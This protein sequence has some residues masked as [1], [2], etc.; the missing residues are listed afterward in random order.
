M[1]GALLFLLKL[2]HAGSIP[3]ELPRKYKVPRRIHLIAAMLGFALFVRTSWADAVV[4]QNGQRFEGIIV[5]ETERRIVI[6]TPG[7]E[8]TIPRNK[9]VSVERSTVSSN[10]AIEIENALRSEAPVA[11]LRAAL[12]AVEEGVDPESLSYTFIENRTLI[13]RGLRESTKAQ[14]NE[15]RHLL[16]GLVDT[17]FASPSALH[18]MAQAYLELNS[19]LEASQCLHKAGLETLEENDETREWARDFLRRL[20]RELVVQGRHKEAVEQ[21]ERL[22]LVDPENARGQLPLLFLSTS[23][24]AREDD[25]FEEACRIL[26][27]ELAPIMPEIAANRASLTLREMTKWAERHGREKQAR[28]LLEI[29][30]MPL[31]PL[32]SIAARQRLYA[33]QARRHLKEA[34]PLRALRA[35]Q[36]VPE[37]ERSEELKDLAREAD[38]QARLQDIEETDA[39]SLFDLGIW[40]SEQG[41]Y[42]QA[43]DIFLSVR[44]NDVL[45][46]IVD[47]QMGLMKKE[48]DMM[49]LE[50]ALELYDQGLMEQAVEVCNE[51]ELNPGRET[52]LERQVQELAEL[53]RKELRQESRRRPY[54]AEAFY[55]QAERAY[56]TEDLDLAWRMIDLILSEYADTPAAQRAA[57]LLPDVARQ[58]ELQL[59]EGRRKRVPDYGEAYERESIQKSESLDREIRSLLEY[60]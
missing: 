30:L 38:F 29:Y 25:D 10:A 58:L 21:I 60:M 44:E 26:H 41:L 57:A 36:Q 42:D 7:G 27:D 17:D 16:R 53:A 37:E 31:I 39:P 32:E 59:L 54:Q 14:Q 19:P 28:E 45:R 5:L 13:L 50:H 56:F 3:A 22:R 4:H 48:H 34:D 24:R 6:R 55:Q 20:V 8:L 15:A 33:S 46:P 2:T 23:A 43:H 47:E 52:R 51:M 18:V 11:A 40:A 35:V 12:Q 1:T 49:L 9:I